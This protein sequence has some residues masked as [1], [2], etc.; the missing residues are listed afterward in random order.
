MSKLNL[1]MQKSAGRLTE[2]LWAFL[3]KPELILISKNALFASSTQFPLELM[4]VRDDDI[5]E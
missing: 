5:P 4:L 2:K 3:N 1:A